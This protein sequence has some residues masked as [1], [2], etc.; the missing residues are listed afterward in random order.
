MRGLYGIDVNG[1]GIQDAWQAPTGTFSSASL[2]DGS[3]GAQSRLRQIVAVRMGVILR[4][5]LIEKETVAPANLQL[6]GD[7][8]ASLQPPPRTLSASERLSRHRTIEFTVPLRN[9]LLL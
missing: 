9:M 3:P 4:T 5:S 2:L 8:D 1:D 7:L 6:F